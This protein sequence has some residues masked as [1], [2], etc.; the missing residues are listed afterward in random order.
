VGFCSLGSQ[1]RNLWLQSKTSE[2]GSAM[3]TIQL[4]SHHHK[5]RGHW[6]VDSDSIPTIVFDLAAQPNLNFA[7][8]RFL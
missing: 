1:S 6:L 2:I 8:R 7:L 3:V 5:L 4:D